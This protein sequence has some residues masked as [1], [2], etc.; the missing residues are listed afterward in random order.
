MN[1]SIVNDVF[2][3]ILTTGG[4]IVLIVIA[5]F[6][7]KGIK[8][9]CLKLG[10]NIDDATMK[11]IISIVS[12]AIKYLDQKFVDTIK[13]NSEDGTLT[14]QQQELIKDKCIDLVRSMLTSDQVEYLLNKYKMDDLDDIIGVLIESNI[15]DAR[16][17]K[18][19]SIII[20]ENDFAEYSE[21]EDEEKAVCM[22]VCEPSEE[23]LESIAACPADC[24]ICPL[25]DDCEY[26]RRY[27]RQ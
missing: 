8:L 15:K 4:L 9:L 11:G 5:A 17:G 25:A 2:T 19:D 21:N 22:N 3:T 27:M 18:E 23:E 24:S 10:I 16:S 12:S 6:S 26:D 14:T 1:W 20:N 7:I 13:K